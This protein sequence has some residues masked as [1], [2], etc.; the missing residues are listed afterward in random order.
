MLVTDSGQIM[1]IQ[2]EVQKSAMVI[3][4][5][6]GGMSHREKEVKEKKNERTKVGERGRIKSTEQRVN[7][8]N[9]KRYTLF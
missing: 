8:E 1:V 7:F 3:F 6:P 2:E 4:H 9:R 5:R